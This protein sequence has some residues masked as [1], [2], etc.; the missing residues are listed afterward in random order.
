MARGT[1]Q[2]SGTWQ[3]TNSSGRVLVLAAVGVVLILADSV[4]AIVQAVMELVIAVAASAVVLGAL[5]VVGVVWLTRRNACQDAGVA[6]MLT[7]RRE[8]FAARREAA[9]LAAR[10]AREVPQEAPPAAIEQ[11]YHVH[12]HAAPEP[13]R[14]VIPWHPEEGS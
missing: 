1:W 3:T 5:A 14:A 13:A 4:A 9:A 7:A 12:F 8:Q 11:H 2:G 6:E 10:T